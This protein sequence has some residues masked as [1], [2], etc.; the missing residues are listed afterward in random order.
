MVLAR[1]RRRWLNRG[2]A[3]VSRWVKT[4]N[5]LLQQPVSDGSTIAEGSVNMGKVE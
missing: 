3:G 4:I 1:V 2:G 5:I